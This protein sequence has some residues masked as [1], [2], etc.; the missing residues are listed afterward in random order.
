MTLVEILDLYDDNYSFYIKTEQGDYFVDQ[1]NLGRFLLGC[2][3][4]LNKNA[5]VT[6][7]TKYASKVVFIDV[8]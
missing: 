6:F 7:E 4:F 1:D 5:R 3:F 2:S 8:F